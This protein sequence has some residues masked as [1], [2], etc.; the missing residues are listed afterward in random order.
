MQ[1]TTETSSLSSLQT[2]I[3]K[4]MLKLLGIQA[5]AFPTLANEIMPNSEVVCVIF[6]N[7]ASG[8]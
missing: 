3:L 1:S 5:C 2:C 8:T 4:Q 6:K 7:T